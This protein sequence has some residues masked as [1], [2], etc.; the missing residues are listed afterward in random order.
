MLPGA[1][2]TSLHRLFTCAMFSQEYQDNMAQE[3][4]LCNV[5]WILSDN[6]GQVFY[7]FYVVPGVLR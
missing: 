7:L 5:V 6:T 1:S 3:F 2:R 4:F